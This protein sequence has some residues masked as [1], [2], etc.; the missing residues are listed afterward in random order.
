MIKPITKLNKATPDF[1][2]SSG[3]AGKED[4]F[5]FDPE[6]PFL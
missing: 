2:G 3:F 5:P 6:N 1:Y 4:F